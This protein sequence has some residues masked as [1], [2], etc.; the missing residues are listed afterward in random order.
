MVFEKMYEDNVKQYEEKFA[1]G[2]GLQY[3]NGHVIRFNKKVLESQFGLTSGNVLD[4]GC[5]SG[6]HAKYFAD[7]GFTLFGCDVVASAIEDCKK[8]LPEFADNFCCIPPLPTNLKELFGGT[9]FDLI[10]SNQVLYYLNDADIRKVVAQLYGLAKPG[11][12][13]YASMMSRDSYYFKRVKETV[14]GMSKVVL[15]GRL[16]ESMYINFKSAEELPGLFK[17]FSKF[18]VGGYGMDFRADE[19]ADDHRLFVGV[20]K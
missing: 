12:V 17:P 15:D 16:N 11:A 9:R 3:P 14:G 5:G 7:N 8:L 18:Y 6:I 10:F 2:D 20:K 13:F 4:Y 19:G 1:C